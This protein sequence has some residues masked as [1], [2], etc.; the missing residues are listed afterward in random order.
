MHKAQWEAEAR[1]L[2]YKK[3]CQESLQTIPPGWEHTGSWF[4]PLPKAT[5][6]PCPVCL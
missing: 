1:L 6:D 5:L 2:Q 3:H 4:L